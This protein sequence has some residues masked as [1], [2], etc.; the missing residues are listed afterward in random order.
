MAIP[1]SNQNPAL[2]DVIQVS[3]FVKNNSR[4]AN[5]VGQAKL[6]DIS[7]AGLC[8]EISS[9]DSDLFM[10]SQGKLFV[11]NSELE[12]QLFCRTHPTNLFVAGSIEWFKRKK[13]V[14]DRK[15]EDDGNIYVGV[16]FP[17]DDRDQKR[18][19]VELLRRLKRETTKCNQCDAVVSASA[20]IC[21]NCGSNPSSKKT[22]F[23]KMIFSFLANN[24][25]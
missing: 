19:V 11:I 5:R 15:D 7:E 6:V 17:A 3:Y 14:G 9:L 24:G 13:E 22:I 18:D 10:E 23:K 21:Y 25:R 12:M 2:C 20:A 16:I 1:L 4:K 8:M